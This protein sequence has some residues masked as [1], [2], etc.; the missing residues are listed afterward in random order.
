LRRL[1]EFEAGIGYRFR[2]ATLLEQALTHR[3]YGSPHNERLEF[4]GDSVLGC[5][6]AEALYA[7]YPE[8]SEGELTRMKAALVREETLSEAALGLNAAA[9]IRLGEG[10]RARGADIRPSILAD[11]LEAVFGAIFID[12]GYAA[13]RDVILAVY[14]QRLE[15]ID[16]QGPRKDPKT[17]LQEFLQA[18]HKSRP[19]YHVLQVRGA[20]HRQTFDVECVVAELGARATGSGT[21]R[22]RAEQQAAAALLESIGQ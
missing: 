5:I 12:G 10:E 15:H 2:D 22:Q 3:S 8:L 6:M 20:A 13:V 19:E 14:A 1:S 17:R 7:R 11:V 9:V 21:S 18:Q 16:P 4:L